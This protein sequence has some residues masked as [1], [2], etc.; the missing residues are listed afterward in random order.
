MEYLFLLLKKQ[1][2]WGLLE[3]HFLKGKKPLFICMDVLLNN[4]FKNTFDKRVWLKSAFLC[5]DLK[6]VS[7]QCIFIIK[8][9]RF[10]LPLH[11]YFLLTISAFL[12]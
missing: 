7:K 12:R 11:L 2:Q 5:I 1:Q 4:L 10:F 6:L 8:K 9:N 3:I